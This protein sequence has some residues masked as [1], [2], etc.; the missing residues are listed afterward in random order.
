M[1]A[2]HGDSGY[3]DDAMLLLGRSLV[4]LG[5]H[6][7]A[8]ATFARLLERFPESDHAGAARLGMARAERLGGDTGTARAAL[9]PLLA[10]LEEAARPEVLHEDAMIALEEGNHA[11]A[12]AAFRRILDEHPDYGRR[13]GVALGFADAELAAGRHDFALEAY[14]AYRSGAV[15]PVQRRRADLRFA[16]ALEL[17]GRGTEALA[18]YDTLLETGVPDTLAARIHVLRGALFEGREEWEAATG[19]YARAAELAPGSATGSRAA[20]RRGWI[21]WRVRGEREAALETM[22]DAFLHA[23]QSAHGDS[24][25]TASRRIARILHFAAIAEGRTEVTTLENPALARSTALYR[26]AEEVLDAEKA[27]GPAAETFE[28]LA[29]EYPDSPWRPR[30]LLAAGLLRRRAGDPAGDA[31]LREVLETYADTP[32]ADSA[33]RALGEPVP[34]RP[35]DFYFSPA[36]LDSLARALPRPPDPMVAIAEQMDRYTRAR[37]AAAAG[38]SRTVRPSEE[39]PPSEGPD[40]EIEPSGREFPSGVTP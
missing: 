27:P 30:A 25:R 11:R 5:R 7:D 37:Q 18:T 33:R 39:V 31:R 16:A 14:D 29:A 15:D 28:R 35:G 22:L 13:E 19:A 8:A 26:L 6:G 2:R 12:V 38:Q 1:L 4:E 10:D 21:E 34:E 20:Y 24:A 3:A 32:A 17:A 36:V 40:P 9:A 23:P